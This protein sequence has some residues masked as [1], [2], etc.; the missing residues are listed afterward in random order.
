MIKAT[1]SFGAAWPSMT[2]APWLSAL[3]L[4]SVVLICSAQPGDTAY[5]SGSDAASKS[6]LSPSVRQGSRP[7]VAQ[8]GVA[9]VIKGAEMPSEFVPMAFTASGQGRRPGLLSVAALIAIH[10][11][12]ACFAWLS[13]FA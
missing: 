11:I 1:T 12:S 10:P 4:R 6:L 9:G 2:I 7:K 13:T 5:H 8:L 3:M